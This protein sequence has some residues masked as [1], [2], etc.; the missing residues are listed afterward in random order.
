V[1]TYLLR[2]AKSD[3]TRFG[4][5]AVIGYDAEPVTDNSGRPVGI[6]A[7]VYALD[8][9]DVVSRGAATAQNGLLSAAPTAAEPA[10]SPVS[11]EYTLGNRTIVY[12]APTVAETLALRAASPQPTDPAAGAVLAAPKPVSKLQQRNPM[13]PAMKQYLISN[14][15]LDAGASDEDAQAKFE[16]LSPEDQSAAKASMSAAAPVA[17]AAMAARVQATPQT[18]AQLVTDSGEA[19]LAR[20]GKRVTQVGQLA[21][22]L[23][24]PDDVARLS[25][26][27]GDDVIAAKARFLKHLQRHRH[28]DSQREGG[29]GQEPRQPRGGH[30]RRHPAPRRRGSEEARTSAP[31]QLRHRSLADMARTFFVSLG[32]P[33]EEAYNLSPVHVAEL[34]GP[35]NFA[36]KYPQYA[37]LAQ[38]SSDFTSILADTINKT[39]RNA[40]MDAPRTWNIWARRTTNPTSRRSP[41]RRC[42]VAGPDQPGRG[43]GIKYVTLSDSKETYALTEYTGGIKLTRRAIINDDL[44]AFSRIPMLQGNAAARKEDDVAYAIITANAA[45]ADTGTLFNATAVTTAGGHANYTSSGLAVSSASLAARK[46]CC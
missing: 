34:L 14:H 41:A 32:V 6:V 37:Q 8:A 36:R 4:L 26:A 44:D 28:A 46:S 18:R 15:G 29:R 9:I 20:E 35:R 38:S 19:E 1:R 43:Q 33:T 3:P 5:S 30:P 45:M 7:R 31:Q 42:R 2:R 27:Q 39:L 24:V 11:I 40:Y 13:D 17:A 23:K 10:A 12:A 22:I 16:T 25:I 21:A